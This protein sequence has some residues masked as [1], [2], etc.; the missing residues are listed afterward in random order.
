MGTPSSRIYITSEIGSL[1]VRIH[2]LKLIDGACAYSNLVCSNGFSV[3]LLDY[4]LESI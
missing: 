1:K 3:F 2:I 4:Y